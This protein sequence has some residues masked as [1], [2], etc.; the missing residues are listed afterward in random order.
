MRKPLVAIGAGAVAGF[1]SGLLGVGGGLVLVPLLVGVVSFSQHH[2]HATSLAAVVLIATGG[3]VAF[4][5]AGEVDLAA[6]GLLA[7]GGLFGAPI[8]AKLMART[9]EARLKTVL[10]L[11]MVTVGATLVIW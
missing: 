6:A 1:A 9:S 2:A 5:G 4:G 3:A 7:A 8:G 10:G 11:F